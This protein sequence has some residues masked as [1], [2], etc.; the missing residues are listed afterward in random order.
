MGAS[1]SR[2]DAE[3]IAALRARLEKAR[4]ALNTIGPQGIRIPIS[5]SE[6]RKEALREA[7]KALYESLGCMPW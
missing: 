3:T 7:K 6:Q 2:G 4:E 5:L 1:S